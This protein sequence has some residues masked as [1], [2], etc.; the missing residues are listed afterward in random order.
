[1]ISLHERYRLPLDVYLTADTMLATFEADYPALMTRLRSAT[2][3]ALNYRSPA[4]AY[5]SYDW[6]S[7]WM[8]TAAEQ[9][10]VRDYEVHVTDPVT[11]LPAVPA[12]GSPDWSSTPPATRSSPRYRQVDAVP[13]RRRLPRVGRDDDRLPLGGLC[14][15]LG[16]TS[17]WPCA[18]NTPT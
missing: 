8:K 10:A 7:L 9:L 17:R 3:F 11:G 6:A 16:T 18:L 12:A 5:A 2:L 1:M 14:P 13:E 4:Q 15:G